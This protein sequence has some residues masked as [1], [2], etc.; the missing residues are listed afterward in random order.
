MCRERDV[1]LTL[2]TKT[3]P[4][5]VLERIYAR[6]DVIFGENRV[7]ELCDKYIEGA[8]WIFIGRLQK[9]KVKYLVDK[10]EMICSVDSVDL[11][12]EIQK[13]CLAKGKVMPVLIE[14]NLGETQKGGVSAADLPSLIATVQAC[15][16]L[17]WQ[18]IMAVLPREGAEE[19]A[20][21]ASAIYRELQKEYPLRYLSMGMSE[22]Y[23]IAM[24]AGANMVR[25]GSAVFGKRS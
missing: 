13:R 12:L 17:V 7:Q 19:A 9:N 20:D 10:V 5:D 25:L 22:D 14:I 21:R 1:T 4:R 15:P 6:Y 2:A 16:N 23:Q 11:A 8:H 24:D 3:I 18:G